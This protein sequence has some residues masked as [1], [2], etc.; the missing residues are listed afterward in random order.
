MP[1]SKDIRTLQRQVDSVV[2]S[3]KRST[4]KN[5]AEIPKSSN[6]MLYV[7][8]SLNIMLTIAS[9]ILQLRG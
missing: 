9:L 6:K 3:I 1:I 5:I 4:E 8:I 2:E 7:L